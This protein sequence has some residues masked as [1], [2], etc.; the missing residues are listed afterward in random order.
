MVESLLEKNI[1]SVPDD[2]S[3]WWPNQGATLEESRL[4]V[5][6]PFKPKK[7]P[8]EIYLGTFDLP[9]PLNLETPEI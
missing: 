4:C 6:L 1:L 5:A 3:C 2:A 9:L 7:N 8:T